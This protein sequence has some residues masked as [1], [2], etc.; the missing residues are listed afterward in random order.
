MNKKLINDTAYMNIPDETVREILSG[1]DSFEKNKE[2]ISN[3]NTLISLA[4][5][6]STNPNYLSKVINHHKDA[7]LVPILI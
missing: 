1:L 7:R 4:K 6:L 2:F 5:K 3:K